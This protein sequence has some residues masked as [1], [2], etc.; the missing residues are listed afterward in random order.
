[1]KLSNFSVGIRSEKNCPVDGYEEVSLKIVEAL[2]RLPL[3]IKTIASTL[4]NRRD[5][6]DWDEMMKPLE[7]IRD[8]QIYKSLKVSYDHLTHSDQRSIFLD[9]ASFFDGIDQETAIHIWD[10][11]GLSSRKSIKDLVMEN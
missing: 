8:E 4:Y 6:E 5:K 10:A 2:H 7:E 9:I 1:M 3:A 11:C